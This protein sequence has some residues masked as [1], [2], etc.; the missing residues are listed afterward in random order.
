MR[1]GFLYNKYP[2][3]ELTIFNRWGTIVKKING[4]YSPWNGRKNGAKMPAGTYYYVINLNDRLS[5][6]K[7]EGKT[8]QG[9]LTLIK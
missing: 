2:Y 9:T 7:G 1:G 3:I 4:K 6:A 8:V 5:N